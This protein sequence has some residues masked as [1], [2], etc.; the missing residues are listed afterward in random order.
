METFPDTNSQA[1]IHL[2]HW[3]LRGVQSA[4][5]YYVSCTPYN[6]WKYKR[7]RAREAKE[8]QPDVV[9]TQPGLVRQPVAFQTNEG[10]GEEMVLGPGPPPEFKKKEHTFVR[11]MRNTPN[12]KPYPKRYEREDEI[13]AGFT[14][15]MM[16]MWNRFGG[17]TSE[18]E[19]PS[20]LRMKRASTMESDRYDYY[21]GENPALNTLHPPV[22]SRLPATMNEAAWMIM[23]PPSA[24]VMAGKKSPAAEIEYRWP[25]S[26]IGSEAKARRIGMMGSEPL[27]HTKSRENFGF[28]DRHT[29]TSPENNLEQGDEGPDTDYEEVLESPPPIEDDDSRKIKHHS[30]PAIRLPSAVHTKSTAP[31]DI[32]IPKRRGSWHFQYLVPSERSVMSQTS[33]TLPTS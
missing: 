17:E 13:L 31:D 15:K 4:V 20:L 16:R 10:W 26:M 27:A 18:H 12:P 7:K 22:D 29:A 25:M 11:M 6:E 8:T 23:A 9:Y 2:G 19:G 24:A 21:R 14:D 32:F 30:D 5:Y 1:G 28:R 33:Y 3:F